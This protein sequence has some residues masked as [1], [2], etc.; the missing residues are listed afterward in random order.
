MELSLKE[1]D[2]MAVMRQVSEGG[3]ASASAASRLGVTR[4]HMRCLPRTSASARGTGRRTKPVVVRGL[5][6][7]GSR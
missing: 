1:R 7:L 4:R 2:R 5:E 3:L 6:A